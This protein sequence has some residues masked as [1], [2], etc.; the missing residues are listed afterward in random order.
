MVI[1]LSDINQAIILYET[2]YSHSDLDPLHEAILLSGEKITSRENLP[3]H[4]TTSAVIINK[5]NQVL[6]IKHKFLN[7]WL[8]P[9]GHCELEDMTLIEAS[10]REATEETI[11]SSELLERVYPEN[12]LIDIDLHDIPPNLQKKEPRHWHADFRFVFRLRKDKQIILQKEEVSNYVWLS[13]DKMAMKR[14]AG[15]LDKLLNHDD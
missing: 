7:K 6:R 5:H 13:V 1:S 12:L 2:N 9:G 3:G 8:L 14:L 15:K 10:L 11:I 4:I